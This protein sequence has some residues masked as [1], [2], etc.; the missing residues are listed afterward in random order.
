MPPPRRVRGRLFAR[1]RFLRRRGRGVR[2]RLPEGGGTRRFDARA[3]ARADC[4]TVS[5]GGLRHPGRSG[6]TL[7]E[8]PEDISPAAARDW[9]RRAMTRSGRRPVFRTG[10]WPS[11]ATRRPAR[12]A[13]EILAGAGLRSG[14]LIPA[15]PSRPWRASGR[16]S[17]ELSSGPARAHRSIYLLDRQVEGDGGG[18][19]PPAPALTFPCAG[20]PVA[21]GG[22]DACA[23]RVFH[24][25]LGLGAAG[26]PPGTT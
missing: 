17:Q 24:D 14:D 18:P 4:S 8:N 10:L 5:R 12:R 20:G 15:C 3:A 16:A 25:D 1:S 2:F 13:L 21:G 11:E 23:R 22:T 26:E 19:P 6:V 9:A 7:E